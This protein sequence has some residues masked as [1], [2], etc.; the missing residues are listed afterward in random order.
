MLRTLL[1]VC[2]AGLL[3]IVPAARLASA[4]PQTQPNAF[5]HVRLQVAKLGT[6]AKARA[7][8]T[9]SDGTKIKGY[10]FSADDKDF[11]MRDPKTDAPTTIRYSDVA[12]VSP[13][14]GHSTA[15][16]LGLGIAIGVGAFLAVVGIVFL[17]MQD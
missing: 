13:D 2:A 9:R 10:V 6:G 5:D 3:I 4:Q 17:K 8:V 11:V 16:N 15:R 7:T 12:K 14:Q 1:S